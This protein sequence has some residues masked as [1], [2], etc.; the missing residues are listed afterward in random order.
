MFP[1][2]E[3]KITKPGALEI[4]RRAGIEIPTM[5]KLGYSNN[6]CVGCVKGGKGYW[7]KIRQDFPEQFD[8]MAKVE[9][10]IGGTCIKGVY[11]DELDPDA[12]REEKQIQPECDLF[13]EVEAADIIDKETERLE[14]IVG[15]RFSDVSLKHIKELLLIP[16]VRVE[17]NNPATWVEG[18]WMDLTEAK[19]LAMILTGRKI[20][21]EISESE[22][23]DARKKGLVVVFGSSDDLAELRGA[24]CDE[25]SCYDGGEILFV[26]GDLYQ[27]K[28]EDEGCPHEEK[29]QESA[30]KIEVVWGG[31]FTW[32]YQTEIPHETF[33]IFDDEEKYCRGIV[34]NIKDI[35]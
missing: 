25:V 30:Q 13:C 1:L 18:G 16:N 19:K 9:R 27:S 4:V 24:I 5:Y 26:D 28:C 35:K 14:S 12:G 31:D 20:G 2:I 29:I 15:F 3:K 11:L 32:T 6:N 34:F 7:N 17:L 23:R 22:E 33:E 21:N 10:N 8:R